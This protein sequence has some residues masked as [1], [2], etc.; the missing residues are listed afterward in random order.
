M[1]NFKTELHRDRRS[2]PTTV[3]TGRGSTI[4]RSAPEG[5]SPG[6]TRSVFTQSS[7]TRRQRKSR[8][9]TVREPRP[10]WPGETKKPNGRVSRKL[11]PIHWN[12]TG[13]AQPFSTPLFLPLTVRWPQRSGAYGIV[14]SQ[15]CS[16]PS[17]KTIWNTPAQPATLGVPSPPMTPLPTVCVLPPRLAG[18]STPQTQREIAL[19][20]ATLR[21]PHR[22]PLR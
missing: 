12:T 19:L 8:T 17:D 13:A 7:T 21:S 22:W 16:N 1:G 3:A 11:R 2:S 6:S 15:T 14:V 4:S 18:P 9:T 20:C 5:G 10:T